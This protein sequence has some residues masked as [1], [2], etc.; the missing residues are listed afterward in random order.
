V[1][2]T[3]L[4]DGLPESGIHRRRTL[5]VTLLV[6]LSGCAPAFDSAEAPS[7]SVSP[8]ASTSTSAADTAFPT[9]KFADI[10]EDAVSEEASAEFQAI[11][12][13]GA[14]GGGMTATVM[15]AN[16][17]WSGAVGSADGTREM[18]PED[19]L[20][21]GSITK[22]VIA[23]QVMRLAEAGKLAL[24]DAAANHLPADFEFD[25]NQATIRQLLGMR[26][27]I[28][29]YVDALWDSLSTDR[30]HHWTPAEMLKLVDLDRTPPDG[31]YNYSSTNYVLLGLII[32]HVT[33]E[34]LA[35]V[36]RKGV[37][38]SGGLQRLIFQPDEAPTEPMAMPAGESTR[39]LEMGGGYLPSLAGTTAAWAAGAMASDSASVARWWSK[40]CGGEI[41]SET[42]LA[43][44]TTFLDGYGLGLSD[45]TEPYATPVVGH[46]GLH[47]GYAARAMCFV[48]D[49]FVI[50]ILTNRGEDS[51]EEVPNALAIA[52]R[53]IDGDE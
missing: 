41:V 5:I 33:G 23:A 15:T 35:R 42:S 30:Q 43:E 16:G 17:S 37:L 24:D 1:H 50:V 45:D 2:M 52:A 4:T 40:L 7:T 38:S 6:V 32:E 14:G 48:D 12:T 20:A 8:L 39:A 53:S 27:G 34:P 18:R 36:L 44:M 51:G 49:G 21:I 9:A 25:T 3:A 31:T 28:P 29:D 26:S 13:E 19:Q 10:R 46:G 11:L 47:V 22:S